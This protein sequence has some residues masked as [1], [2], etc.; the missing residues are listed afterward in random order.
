MKFKIAVSALAFCFLLVG[1]CF[2]AG[3][4]YVYGELIGTPLNVAQIGIKSQIWYMLVTSV[5]LVGIFCLAYWMDLIS[6]SIKKR[7]RK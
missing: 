7:L 2:G 4:R 5:M 1:P 6:N 3:K